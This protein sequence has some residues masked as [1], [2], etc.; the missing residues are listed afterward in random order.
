MRA[1]NAYVHSEPTQSQ[2]QPGMTKT[3]GEEKVLK[4][5]SSK[6]CTPKQ[7]FSPAGWQVG[8][9]PGHVAAESTFPAVQMSSLPA[10]CVGIFQR[11]SPGVGVS[12]D[13][14]GATDPSPMLWRSTKL[15]LTG[16]NDRRSFRNNFLLVWSKFSTREH[17]TQ[18]QTVRPHP[19]PHKSMFAEGTR[20]ILRFTARVMGNFPGQVG[21]WAPPPCFPPPSARA[22]N[23]E[24]Q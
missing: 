10:T 20:K 16:T 11:L 3:D 21:C 23:R 17:Y 5:R 9:T 1:E 8:R 6:H 13:R 15:C 2:T 19:D 24:V 14:G 12:E 18:S 22:G 4:D 7:H